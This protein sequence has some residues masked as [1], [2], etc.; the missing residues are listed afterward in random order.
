MRC[1]AASDG[2]LRR[3]VDSGGVRAVAR[4]RFRA[5][6]TQM[7]SAH[8]WSRACP[9]RRSVIDTMRHDIVDSALR[10]RELRRQQPRGD[11]GF[12]TSCA[13]R[14]SQAR[15]W[16][17]AARGDAIV[18]KAWVSGDCL[19]RVGADRREAPF[20]Q[21]VASDSNCRR[22]SWMGC[23]SSQPDYIAGETRR[24][25][26]RL[27]FRRRARL[28]VAFRL[29]RQLARVRLLLWNGLRSGG[30]LSLIHI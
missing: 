23:G 13:V 19:K 18:T 4:C 5:H 12:S 28:L 9:R 15:V 20:S 25:R 2:K 14:N 24:S 7:A 8:G 1:T 26:R 11:S 3:R 6:L 29:R 22:D 21:A 27:V 17:R 30:C 10:F 16:L